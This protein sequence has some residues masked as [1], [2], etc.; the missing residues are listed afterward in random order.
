MLYKIRAKFFQDYFLT[1]DTHIAGKRDSCEM[2]DANFITRIYKYS[3]YAISFVW[4]RLYQY[5]YDHD[6][7]ILFIR[8]RGLMV[9]GVFIKLTE[10]NIYTKDN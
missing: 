4:L 7:R 10:A 5:W 6:D 3:L 9:L 2:G 1:R 8:E